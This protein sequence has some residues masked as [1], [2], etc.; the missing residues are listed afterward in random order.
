LAAAYDA[1][2]SFLFEQLAVGGTTPMVAEHVRSPAMHRPAPGTAGA[3]DINAA[4]DDT[5]LSD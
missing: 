3:L 2:F 5:D 4:P 1:K